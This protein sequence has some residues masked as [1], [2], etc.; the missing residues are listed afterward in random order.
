M[1]HNMYSV[2]QVQHSFTN[3]STMVTLWFSLWVP[4]R[5]A[6]WIPLMDPCALVVFSKPINLELTKA[7]VCQTTQS[8]PF[9]PSYSIALPHIHTENTHRDTHRETHTHTHN[10]VAC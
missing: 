9:L 2:L 6:L 7:S 1:L 10:V 3:C 5:V 8:A 4:L